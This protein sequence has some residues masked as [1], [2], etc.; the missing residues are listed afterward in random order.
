MQGNKPQKPVKRITSDEQKAGFT[1]E[2]LKTRGLNTVCT[3]S[4]CPN[5]AECYSK[6]TATFMLL[7]KQCTRSCRFCSVNKSVS[8]GVNID[9]D[10][11]SKIVEAVKALG[12]RYV[13]LTSVTRDDLVDNGAEQFAKTVRLLK[14]NIDGIKVELLIPDFNGRESL[15]DIITK[16]NP[17]VIGHNVETVPR[18]YPEIRP[19]AVFNRSV[20]LI[21][22]LKSVNTGYLIKSGLMVGLGEVEDEVIEVMKALRSAGCDILTI[23]QYL[24]PTHQQVGVYEYIPKEKFESYRRTGE[25]LGFKTVYSGSFVRSSYHAEEISG[26]L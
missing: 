21:E 25:N 18:L 24:Q 3:E 20:S 22:Y 15:V 7:G 14:D 6:K 13:V 10:E 5:Q 12:L 16:S 19:Q 4:R 1:S 17:D 26:I 8:P 9:P 2:L 23:G 11:P